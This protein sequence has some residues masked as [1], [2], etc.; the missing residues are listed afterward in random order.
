MEPISKTSQVV[1]L[2]LEGIDPYILN[3]KNLENGTVELT[4]IDGFNGIFLV[5]DIQKAYDSKAKHKL[6]GGCRC[7]FWFT[8]DT[9][10]WDLLSEDNKQSGVLYFN[11]IKDCFCQT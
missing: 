6:M 2:M 5:R 3:V 1:D 8:W 7:W 9:T 4:N 10:H 11:D